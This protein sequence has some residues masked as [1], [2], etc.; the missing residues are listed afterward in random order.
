M[1][2]P[3][4]EHNAFTLIEL[5][6]VIAIISILAALLF[7]VF[8][9]ARRSAH[10]TAC[11]SNL[12]QV[13][14]ALQMYRADWD[15]HMPRTILQAQPSGEDGTGGWIEGRFAALYPYTKSHQITQCPAPP[16]TNIYD[17]HR[18]FNP[19]T[20]LVPQTG[21]VVALCYNHLKPNREG[22]YTVVREDAS[23]SR[24][25]DSRVEYWTFRNN[26]WLLTSGPAT[27]LILYL[28]FP[29]EPFP[30]L[31]ESER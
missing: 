18:M 14:A 2:F 16:R 13:G 4:T 11:V 25:P 1:T 20:R 30:P 10:M 12:H 22:F 24:I 29:N 6:V 15:D 31:T 28:N 26:R 19:F 9:Q 17:Y 3:Q 21:S 8:A 23:V 5:L 27:G 7:P